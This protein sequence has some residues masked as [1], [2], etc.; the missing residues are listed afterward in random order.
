MTCVI[1]T[2]VQSPVRNFTFM[3][4]VMTHQADLRTVLFTLLKIVLII[5]LCLHVY[6][7]GNE[8]F[9]CVLYFEIRALPGYTTFFFWTLSFEIQCRGVRRKTTIAENAVAV[10]SNPSRVSFHSTS[11][12]QMFLGFP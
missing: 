5:A 1:L 2:R 3:L 9:L 7:K 6:A 12:E 11:N 4:H 8:Q 10:S